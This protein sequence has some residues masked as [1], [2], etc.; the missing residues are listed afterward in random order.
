MCQLFLFD[1]LILWITS[2]E[3]KK[4]DLFFEKKNQLLVGSFFQNNDPEEVLYTSL[5]T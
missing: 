5:T 1:Y 2:F 4:F 3:K